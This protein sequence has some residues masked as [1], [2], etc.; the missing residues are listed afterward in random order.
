M[1]FTV[2]V[3]TYGESE[4]EKLA[5][6]RAVP[7]AQE[8]ADEIIVLHEPDMSI[9]QVRNRAALAAHGDWLVF[10]DADDVLKPGY[11]AAMKAAAERLGG[12]WLLEPRVAFIHRNAA[13]RPKFMQQVPLDQGNYLVVG[14]GVPRELFLRVDGFGDYPHG[15]EDWALWAKCWKAGA[16]VKRVPGA[17]YIAYVNPNSKCRTMWRNKRLQVKTHLQVQKE[18]FP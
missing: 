16:K 11:I 9:A 3:A 15:F 17:V 12:D 8:Q 2:I 1:R 10:L 14:T 4:W 7:S 5:L 6:E 18:L 13:A